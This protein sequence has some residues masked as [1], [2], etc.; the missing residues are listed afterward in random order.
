MRGTG[1]PARGSEVVLTA[2]GLEVVATV[3]WNDG[4]TCGVNF[5]KPIEPL[6]VVRS[7]P[8]VSADAPFTRAHEMRA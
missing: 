1:L 8:F 5:H 2:K 7:N 6:A 4:A 3:V